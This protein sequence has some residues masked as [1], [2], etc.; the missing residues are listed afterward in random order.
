M[1]FNLNPFENIDEGFINNDQIDVDDNYYS[2]IPCTS[3]GYVD[4]DLMSE[5]L[6]VDKSSMMHINAGDLKSKIDYLCANLQMLKTKFS[7]IAVSECWTDLSTEGLINIPGYNKLVRSRADG[8]KG[9]GV[10]LYFNS[11]LNLSAKLRN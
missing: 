10:A 1:K 11:D 9:G 7:I 2:R 6:G 5:R 8:R 3:L 4:T